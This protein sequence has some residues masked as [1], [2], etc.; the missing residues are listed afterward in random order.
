MLHSLARLL[1]V[2]EFLWDDF[3][4]MQYANLFPV[5]QDVD[6]LRTAKD[7]AQLQ[8]ELSAALRSVH[9]GPQAPTRSTGLACHPERVQR[10]R[11]VPHRH[12]P[13]PRPHL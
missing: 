8:T 9:P 2:S 3:L 1:G 6:A 7:R 5:V 13:H 11:D 10:P 12:A 4:R